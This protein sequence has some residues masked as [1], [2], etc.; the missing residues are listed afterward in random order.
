[1]F[2]IPEE[3]ESDIESQAHNIH[4]DAN[5]QPKEKTEEKTEEEKKAIQEETHKCVC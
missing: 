4:K 3:T 5:N 1:M 2:T